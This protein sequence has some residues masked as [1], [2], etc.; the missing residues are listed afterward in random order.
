MSAPLRTTTCLLLALA[1]AASL[2]SD[3]TE[4]SNATP[5]HSPTREESAAYLAAQ[6]PKLY[7]PTVASST[8]RQSLETQRENA[9]TILNKIPNSQ[10]EL[11]LIEASLAAKS[12]A[13]PGAK[14]LNYLI[15][16]RKR[17][18]SNNE[19]PIIVAYLN[20]FPDLIEVI[21][22]HHWTKDAA[23]EILRVAKITDRES[24]G[25]VKALLQID[26]PEARELLARKLL[27]TSTFSMSLGYR[28]LGKKNPPHIIKRLPPD[29]LPWLNIASIVDQAWNLAKK[30]PNDDAGHYAPIAACYGHLDAL[31]LMAKRLGFEYDARNLNEKNM[32]LTIESSLTRLVPLENQSP[33]AIA[34]FVF[35][36]RKKLVFNSEAGTYSLPR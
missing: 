21:V 27:Q 31:I 5:A 32:Q 19:R 26:S 1:T 8:G 22:N 17:E 28:A 36:N 34:R 6:R 30:R 2:F 13:G 35:E 25:Y 18:F 15:N 16:L 9:E 11:I 29:E 20:E 4:K 33:E 7:R 3:S 23:Q 10:I 14:H 24:T 12:S